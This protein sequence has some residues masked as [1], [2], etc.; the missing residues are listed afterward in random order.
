TVSV[1]RQVEYDNGDMYIFV[2]TKEGPID[3]TVINDYLRSYNRVLI[4]DS[5]RAVIKNSRQIQE[6]FYEDLDPELFM[7]KV[8]LFES[9]TS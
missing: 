2:D 6:I 1:A 5:E 8:K 4:M 9:L 7:T 3:D